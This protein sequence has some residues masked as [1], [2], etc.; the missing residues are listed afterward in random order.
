MH[1][2]A[3]SVLS[4]LAA[5]LTQVANRIVINAVGW[6]TLL[7]SSSAKTA[8]CAVLDCATP[9][10]WFATQSLEGQPQDETFVTRDT[11]VLTGIA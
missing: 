4:P 8:S 5:H 2:K 6:E 11:A 1:A 9:E 7:D 3:Q 10:P